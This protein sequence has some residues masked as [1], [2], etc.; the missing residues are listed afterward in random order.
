MGSHFRA[1]RV[2]LVKHHIRD[3][4]SRSVGNVS[5][6]RLDGRQSDPDKESDFI[7]ST[8]SRPTLGLSH[9]DMHVGAKYG[10]QSVKLTSTV[11][12]MKTYLQSVSFDGSVAWTR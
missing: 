9:P 3:N 10:G 6:H 11:E 5:G 2:P 4:R 8:S 12:F 1:K 7:P